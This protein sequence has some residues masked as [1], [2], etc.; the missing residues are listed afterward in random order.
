MFKIT[1]MEIPLLP[2]GPQDIQFNELQT[3]LIRSESAYFLLY[4]FNNK[5]LVLKFKFQF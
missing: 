2:N 4:T 5:K 1:E 3:A